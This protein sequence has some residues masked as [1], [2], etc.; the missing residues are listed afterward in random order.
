MAA[1]N[2]DR[3]DPVNIGSGFEIS[4]KDLVK[5]IARMLDFKGEIKFVKTKP[6]GEQ[7][8]LV[9]STRAKKEI[10]FRAETSFEIGLESTIILYT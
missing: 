6:N 10:G 4:I 1:E 8:R 3:P 5:T 9:D 2:Y 7:K